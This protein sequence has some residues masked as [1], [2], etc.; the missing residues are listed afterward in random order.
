[1]N[2]SF[3]PIAIIIAVVL[4]VIL[5]VLI[6][7][8]T[9]ALTQNVVYLG[10]LLSAALAILA[11]IVS[12]LTYMSID[13]VDAIS[14]MDGNVLENEGY[15][16]DLS[17]ILYEFGS[18]KAQTKSIV[19]M[20]EQPYKNRLSSGTQ[21][22]DNLQKTIDYLVLIPF[23]IPGRTLHK[24]LNETAEKE[25]FSRAITRLLKR[26]Q[27]QVHRFERVNAGSNILIDETF[28]LIKAV[29]Y[30]QVKRYLPLNDDNLRVLLPSVRG[31]MLKNSVSKV[32]Y[33]NYLGLFY[34][35]KA[36]DMMEEALEASM[37]TIR[38][39][40]LCR[41]GQVHDDR[42]MDYLSIAEQS[43]KEALDVIGDDIMWKA[44]ITFNL[45]RASFFRM[46]LSGNAFDAGRL[47]DN[48]VEWRH[49]LNVYIADFIEEN[50][51]DTPSLILIKHAF[52][53]QELQAR[54]QKISCLMATGQSLI[55]L[56]NPDL[57]AAR[58]EIERG[59]DFGRLRLR[60]NDIMAT[61]RDNQT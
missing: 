60:Y 10:S 18:R 34:M 46:S 3:T 59:N 24:E 21:L 22:A 1:M 57:S 30:Q 16:T 39:L 43:F 15:R 45:A 9:G 23:I 48:S 36:Q 31:T 6:C 14:R 17:Q 26:I 20:M 37:E 58:L 42:I 61:F 53:A 29:L 2:K 4:G 56:D 40:S 27:H 11:L 13:S 51:K 19:E 47:F 52:I 55:S 25:A 8:W 50:G 49:R 44:F 41:S 38:G 35:H 54:L 7:I 28:K 33:Y 32:M 5:F 12:I